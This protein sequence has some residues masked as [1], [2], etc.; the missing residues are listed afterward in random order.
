MS[1]AAQVIAQAPPALPSTARR[2]G[3][4]W[5]RAR[6]NRLGML[7]RLRLAPVV[8]DLLDGNRPFADLRGNVRRALSDG[9]LLRRR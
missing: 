4:T 9:R 5:L 8:V 1:N 2:G 3:R 6:R 7:G